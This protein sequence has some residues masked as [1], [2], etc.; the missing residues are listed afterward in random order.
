M[1][2]SPVK[3]TTTTRQS[4]Q[5]A[6]KQ[7][8]EIK[9]TLDKVLAK[10]DAILEENSLLRERNELLA[11]R[12]DTLEALLVDKLAAPSKP[13]ESATIQTKAPIVSYDALI[14][15][16]SMFRH[17]LGDSPKKVPVSTPLLK[18][19]GPTIEQ[20][21]S[22]KISRSHPHLS[23]KKICVPGAKAPRLFYEAVRVAQTCSFD[24]VYVHV[25]TNY[26]FDTDPDV[27][28]VELQQF[29]GALKKLF[30]CKIVF[31]PILP[32]L[33]IRPGIRM[34]YWIIP[35]K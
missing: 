22:A 11:K 18:I 9:A 28:S 16:D 31:S 19:T 14:I 1:V 12:V 2:A 6:Q 7:N 32:L 24:T 15:S 30:P 8:G 21:T 3:S 17:L 4:A 33:P 29:L 27:T 13:S 20:D 35:G 34:I 25:G 10:L 23:I 5:S 26:L